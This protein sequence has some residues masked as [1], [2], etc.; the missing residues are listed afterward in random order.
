VLAV[1]EVGGSLTASL[2]YNSD[3]FDAET[4]VRM[5]GHYA[6]LLRGVADDP[7]RSVALLPC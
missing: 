7:D 5:A 6:T 2:K 4:A 1:F 3:L